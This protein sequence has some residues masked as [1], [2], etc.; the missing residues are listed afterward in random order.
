MKDW[1]VYYL[2]FDGTAGRFAGTIIHVCAHGKPAG[3]AMVPPLVLCIT[4]SCAEKALPQF[5]QPNYIERIAQGEED[6][7]IT[8]RLR[9][10]YLIDSTAMLPGS[11]LP[12]SQL[13]L[14]DRL[15]AARAF[16]A[17]GGR[18]LG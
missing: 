5:W 2:G 3:S 10:R 18:I 4:V 15:P 9:S 17:L 16:V 11:S 1:D 6:P 14:I 12:L 13:R 8:I 7:R